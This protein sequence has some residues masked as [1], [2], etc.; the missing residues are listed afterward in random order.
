MCRLTL[1][2]AQ[3]NAEKLAAEVKKL[4]FQLD[5]SVGAV[6]KVKQEAKELR[7]ERDL[8]QREAADALSAKNKAEDA[9]AIALREASGKADATATLA[10]QTEKLKQQRAEEEALRRTAQG[11][12]ARLK[13][14]L[15]A[16]KQSE[17]QTTRD[18][19]AL[20]DALASVQSAFERE[21]KAR[22]TAKDEAAQADQ[23]AQ[24]RVRE[25]TTERDAREAKFKREQQESADAVLRLRSELKAA[26]KEATDR[27]RAAQEQV[28]AKSVELDA[29]KSE[30]KKLKERLDASTSYIDSM[31]NKQAGA[32]ASTGTM[33]QLVQPAIQ[34]ENV[35]E[36]QCAVKSLQQQ[37]ALLQGINDTLKRKEADL[38]AAVAHLEKNARDSAA[39][40]AETEIKAEKARADV[41]GLTLAVEQL[42][43]V[44][45]VLE[46]RAK[47][48]EGE[49]EAIKLSQSAAVEGAMSSENVMAAECKKLRTELDR[50]QSLHDATLTKLNM[51]LRE[52]REERDGALDMLASQSLDAEAELGKANALLRHE[53]AALKQSVAALELK[54][55][56]AVKRA[57]QIEDAAAGGRS[58]PAKAVKAAASPSK[59]SAVSGGALLEAHEKL[60]QELRETQGKLTVEVESMTVLLEEEMLNHQTTQQQL[61]ETKAKLDLQNQTVDALKSK[62]D[63][64]MSDANEMVN[65]AKDASSADKASLAS[66]QN[67]LQSQNEAC[68]ALKE[69]VSAKDQKLETFRLRI[70]DLMAAETKAAQRH[71]DVRTRLDQLLVQERESQR[72]MQSLQDTKKKLEDRLEEARVDRASEAGGLSAKLADT[73]ARLHDAERALQANVAALEKETSL[74][75]SLQKRVSML[76]AEVDVAR[77]ALSRSEQSANHIIED[78]KAQLASDSSRLTGLRDEAIAEAGKKISSLTAE[79]ESLRLQMRMAAES[80]KDSRAI[81]E[82]QTSHLSKE[83]SE[84]R[85]ALREREAAASAA[86][87]KRQQAEAAVL[88]ITRR[89]DEAES[90]C[91]T[92]RQQLQLALQEAELSRTLA[93]EAELVAEQAQL[94]ASQARR[95]ARDE[96]LEQVDAA[97]REA[98]EWEMRSQDAENRAQGFLTQM[99]A[100]EQDWLRQRELLRSA[101]SS[102]D[103]KVQDVQRDAELRLVESNRLLFEARNKLGDLQP[104]YQEAVDKLAAVEGRLERTEQEKVRKEMNWQ[105]RLD[106]MEDSLHEAKQGAELALQQAQAEAERQAQL[107]LER[108]TTAEADASEARRLASAGQSEISLIAAQ[109]QAELSDMT[110]RSDALREELAQKSNALDR[111]VAETGRVLQE[112]DQLGVALTTLRLQLE[113]SQ[114]LAAEKT[115]ALDA[116]QADMERLTVQLAAAERSRKEAEQH[117]HDAVQALQQASLEKQTLLQEQ[118]RAE[119]EVIASLKKDLGQ[120]KREALLASKTAQESV[121][122]S[123]SLDQQLSE[124]KSMHRDLEIRLQSSTEDLAVMQKAAR[125]TED[126]AARSSKELS[127]EISRLTGALDV[128]ISNAQNLDQQLVAL[129]TE[130]SAAKDQLNGLESSEKET[131]ELVQLLEEQLKL[132]DA[133]NAEMEVNLARI[134]GERDEAKLARTEFSAKSIAFEEEAM[135]LKKQLALLEADSESKR[136]SVEERFEET[137][138]ALAKEKDSVAQLEAQRKTLESNL[139]R[140]EESERSAEVARSKMHAELV[141][142][143]NELEDRLQQF[144]SQLDDVT[145]RAAAD[146]EAL[147]IDLKHSRA[148]SAETTQALLVSE[149]CITA[150]E[151]EAAAAKEAHAK[152]TDSLAVQ[153]EQK[154]MAC[155]THFEKSIAQAESVKSNLTGQIEALELSLS[156]DKARGIEWRHR[157]ERAEQ[158]ASLAQKERERVR[159]ELKQVRDSLALLERT[160][161][162]RAAD[163]VLAKKELEAEQANHKLTRGSIVDQQKLISQ[164]AEKNL[165]LEA[166]FDELKEEKAALHARLVELEAASS[167]AKSVQAYQKDLARLTT[168]RESDRALLVQKSADL[169]KVT[170]ML[171]SFE[172]KSRGGGRGAGDADVAQMQEKYEKL[173]GVNQKLEK[174][175]TTLE[176][177]NQFLKTQLEKAQQQ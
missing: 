35:V 57:K 109:S 104:K 163:V 63:H 142:E 65:S 135:R 37:N 145:V 69:V 115:L 118:L 95:D 19:A 47:K 30:A 58:T 87:M 126:A 127:A 165:K 113:D 159:E 166:K 68:A 62:L 77:E 120:T 84:T 100:S 116:A 51:E 134:R 168:E 60:K 114:I 108:A 70:E 74:A 13:N 5:S 110:R 44:H 148:A 52:A 89:A 4:Q 56:E 124:W 146:K 162:D 85:E 49:L 38:T 133:R 107:L 106:E 12:A 160:V 27:V 167:N 83:L 28:E 64:L 176:K 34:S 92:E 3:G 117:S 172:E 158:D 151:M 157:A 129:Q 141:R 25:M 155:Q 153:L 1:F 102:T 132:T 55:S 66:L 130:A 7:K 112:M 71:D 143:K 140:K 169:Q 42:K 86:E 67:Q 125:Q 45:R 88:V 26:A 43:Q 154:L 29:A 137:R 59:N 32:S 80:A 139:A 144:K 105:I 131:A 121:A 94:A 18:M 156:E 10:S 122:L 103:S 150:L 90:Q 14:E 79:L 16:L 99:N 53:N 164:H 17:A 76:E 36:L 8:L 33:P 41:N 147:L 54:A 149:K 136:R 21:K 170:A 98:E 82:D 2:C 24:A 119:D 152:S 31:K 111:A 72:V 101:V 177:K 9:L 40:N 75:A 138:A 93:A 50:V 48:A 161:A 97:K 174:Q 20:K 173:I 15:E 128:A 61:R 91:R 6:D 73:A 23:A 96:L 123:S 175:L 39:A 11:E 22:Q 171:V 78:L 81:L 46:T